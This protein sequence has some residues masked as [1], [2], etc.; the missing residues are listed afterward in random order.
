MNIAILMSK[1]FTKHDMFEKTNIFNDWIVDRSNII[2]TFLKNF[3][4]C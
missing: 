4:L 2:K 1:G 3:V